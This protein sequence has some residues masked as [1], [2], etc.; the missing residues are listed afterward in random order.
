[1][2]NSWALCTL[3]GMLLLTLVLFRLFQKELASHWMDLAAHPQIMVL[4]EEGADD[5]KRLAEMDPGGAS[6]YRQR[7]ENIQQAR[8]SLSVLNVSR[9]RLTQRFEHFLLFG[10]AAI[11]VCAA[12]MHLVEQRRKARRLALLRAPLAELATGSEQ[13]SIEISGS[14]TVSQMARMIEKTAL[15]ISGQRERIQYLRHLREWQETARRWGHEL[16]TPLTTIYLEMNRTTPVLHGLPSAKSDALQKIFESVLEEVGRLKD[17]ANSF[18]SFAGMGQPR[19]GRWDLDGYL[20]HFGDLFAEAWP[21]V[22]LEVRP[23]TQVVEAAFDK[24]MIRQ[25]LMNLC[26]NSVHAFVEGKGRLRF[27][28]GME[29]DRPF[30]DVSDD[31]PGIPIQLGKRIFDPY[32]TTRKMGKGMGLGLAISRKILLEHSG[33]LRL[34]ETG[35]GGSR[36]RLLFQSGWQSLE[37]N[38]EEHTL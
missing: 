20:Q 30:I 22:S 29:G 13:V 35:P 23:A 18:S 15:V 10:L 9:P 28:C 33:D 26:N 21:G 4:L 16:R 7:F 11:L 12:L 6:I 14:D 27:R 19:L 25:V 24:S 3:A 17:F 38:G 31:G 32:V 2:K 5:L 8:R 36:F 1:M 34:M 37:K